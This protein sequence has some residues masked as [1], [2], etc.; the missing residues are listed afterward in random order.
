M[1][2][3]YNRKNIYKYGVKVGERMKRNIPKIYIQCNLLFDNDTDMDIITKEIGLNPTS[4]KNKKEQ[5]KSPFKEGNLEGFWSI[6]TEK[7]ETFLLEDVTKIM[8]KKIK[9]YLTQIKQVIKKYQGEVDFLIVPDFVCL[10]TPALCFDREF[11]DVVE[12]LN[13]TIQIDMYVE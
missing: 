8:V 12:F 3:G 6:E 2:N 9:P 10:D 11:L 4:C 7:V 13:A 5:R 1:A